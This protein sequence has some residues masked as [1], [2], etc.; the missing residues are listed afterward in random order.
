MEVE[1]PGPF[2]DLLKPARYKAYHGGRASAKSHSF[3]AVLVLR[4]AEKPIRWLFCREIQK[5]LTA[6][7]HQLLRD[8]I[9]FYGLDH[10]YTITKDGIRGANGTHF[11]FAGLRSNPDSIKSMEGL[12]GAWIEEAHTC[13]Q[14]SLDI[15]LPTVRKPGSEIWFSWNRRRITDPVD[16]MF[17]GGDPPP[18]SVVHK[19]DW[20]Q[21]P[22]FPDVLRAEMEYLRSRDRDRWLHVWEGEPLRMSNSLVFPNWR[23][24]DLDDAIPADARERFG[25]DWGFSIDPTVLIRVYT[26]G[27]TLYISDEVYKVKCEIDEIPSLFAGSDTRIPERWKN[28][29]GHTGVPGAARGLIVAD[30]ARPETISYLNK[31]GFNIK[32]AVKGARSVEEGV[33]FIRSFDIVVNPR[34]KHAIAELSMYSYQIDKL[35]DEVLPVLADKNNHVIDAIR[36]A[37]EA[38]R[39]AKRTSGVATHVQTVRLD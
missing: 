38:E 1:L 10:F 24:D 18:G 39:R 12:D 19:V 21:N 32:R 17:L 36:Y 8:K 4:G 6:S 14:A 23:E 5:S 3:A 15:L 25:A 27:R 31:R 11:L 22:F 13:S 29:H 37:V 9:S 7:V 30:G 2:R 20:R 26:F 35:T 28:R 33:E 34:C 16:K